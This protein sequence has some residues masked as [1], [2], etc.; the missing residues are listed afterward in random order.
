MKM[1]V[2]IIFLLTI[3]FILFFNAC[4]SSKNQPPG[5]GA[6]DKS[7]TVFSDYIKQVKPIIVQRCDNCHSGRSDKYSSLKNDSY[8]E[9]VKNIISSDKMPKDGPLSAE[10]KKIVLDWLDSILGSSGM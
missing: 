9:K 3:V 1:H 2:I 7:D 5:S 8:T 4:G 6:M 10:N